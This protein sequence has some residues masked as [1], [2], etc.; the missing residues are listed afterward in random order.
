LNADLGPAIRN[1]QPGF[2]I[3]EFLK[4]AFT[5]RE[6]IN[7]RTHKH[8][9]VADVRDGSKGEMTALKSDF[10]YTPGSGHGRSHVQKCEA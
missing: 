5:K 10:R 2:F 9:A 7:T 4:R 6:L 1:G 8:P 3:S